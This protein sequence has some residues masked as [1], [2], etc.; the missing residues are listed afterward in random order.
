MAVLSVLKEQDMNGII[1]IGL[2]TILAAASVIDLLVPLIISRKYPGYNHLTDTISTLGSADSPVKKYQGIN[3][4]IAGILFILFSTGEYLYSDQK[5]WS[6]IWYSVSIIIF[7]IGCIFAGF[8]P[9]DIQGSPETISGKIHGITSGIG[10]LFL[11]SAPLSAIWIKE[12]EP[13]KTLNLILFIPGLLTFA[14]FIISEKI[15][16]GILKFTGLFQR[17]DLVILYGSLNTNFLFIIL[18]KAR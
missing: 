5:S 1:N 14:L 4:V 10:F 8:F 3:L 12:L 2:L 16:S 7:G 18:S 17:L 15:T 9:E 11:I 13:L 6:F